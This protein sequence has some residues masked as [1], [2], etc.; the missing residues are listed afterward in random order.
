MIWI[1]IWIEKKD[2]CI[3]LK[4]LYTN[5]QGF[6]GKMQSFK[7]IMDETDANIALLTET[8]TSRPKLDDKAYYCISPKKSTGQNVCIVLKGEYLICK[9]MKLYDQN[10][11]INM[12]GA[13]IEI[14]NIGIRLYTA[15]LKQISSTDKDEIRRQFHEIQAQF[16][17]ARDSGEAMLLI[18]DSNVH[19]GNAIKQCRDKQDWGGEEIMQLIKKEDL[20][21]IN[22]TS[23]CEGVVTRVDP[24]N[25]TCSTLYL[26]V[27]NRLMIDKI[28]E[29]MIDEEGLHKPRKYTKKKVTETD[30]NTI[31]L[32]LVLERNQMKKKK[33]SF[34]DTKNEDGRKKLISLLRSDDEMKSMF[35]IG[36]HTNEMF[37]R[38]EQ[39]WE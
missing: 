21:L 25:G 16:K 2:K 13:R 23:I 7:H 37:R 22:N 34:F 28:E 39:K 20:I 5:I 14:G 32:G 3:R 36:N 6:T 10:E 27:C 18:M 4:I 31:L 12:I 26:A 19:V 30:H 11:L 1:W 29:M 15:H 35:S 24:R 17:C 38:F 33:V 8:M 9:R